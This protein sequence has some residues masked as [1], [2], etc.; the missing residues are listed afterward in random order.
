VLLTDGLSTPPPP[1]LPPPPP[2]PQ[3]IFSP[4]PPP[5][6]PAGPT[7]PFRSDYGVFTPP[8][9]P[10]PPGTL[11]SMPAKSRHKLRSL[12]WTKIPA[13]R[14]G[15]NLNVWNSSGANS[16]FS[17]STLGPLDISDFSQLESLFAVDI[18]KPNGDTNGTDH[19]DTTAAEKRKKLE[20]VSRRL[21]Y[22]IINIW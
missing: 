16:S 21:K 20:E 2:P 1:P 3:S 12:Q 11:N 6:P 7:S 5:P 4:P 22:L 17:T 8:A 19:R 9:P 18:A 15:G 14:I 13:M 10:V